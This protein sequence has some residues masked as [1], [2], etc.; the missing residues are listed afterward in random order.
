[1][2]PVQSLP[3]IVPPLVA[4]QGISG[5]LAVA[6]VVEAWKKHSWAAGCF[7]AVFALL[8]LFTKSIADVSPVIGL[9]LA[10][11]GSSPV[12]WWMLVVGAVVVYLAKPYKKHASRNEHEEINGGGALP[13]YDDTELRAEISKEFKRYN[14]AL[15]GIQGIRDHLSDQINQVRLESASRAL[16]PIL[17]KAIEDVD[18]A[19]ASWESRVNSVRESC[20][21]GE[22][23]HTMGWQGDQ[24]LRSIASNV[25]LD[26]PNDSVITQPVDT[27]GM[28]DD[29]LRAQYIQF[30]TALQIGKARA[31]QIKAKLKQMRDYC[32][33]N[34][35]SANKSMLSEVAERVKG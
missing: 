20:K 25:G 1:M 8:A 4:F 13:S 11:I 3:S 22:R 2:E 17:G 32:D 27:H 35:H 6:L 23:P 29:K 34:M 14:D 24:P 7:A 19:L 33:G 31:A 12:S 9:W 28:D 21:A 30:A 16:G 15:A 18:T 10:E 5:A 26:F